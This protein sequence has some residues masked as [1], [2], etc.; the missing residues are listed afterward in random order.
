MERSSEHKKIVGLIF[1]A[2]MIALIFI[3]GSIVKIPTLNGFIQP[4]D[5][6]VL[7]GAV[8]LGKKKGF[9][10]AAIGMALVDV[11]A[12]YVIWAPFTF[13]IK[14]LMALTV[15]SILE[16]VEKKSIKKYIGAF[17]VGAIVNL[18]GYFIGNAIM[19]GIITGASVGFV[20]SILYAASHFVG[21]LSEVVV[22]II[23]AIPLA[24]IAQKARIKFLC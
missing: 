7:A 9:I 20:G 24:P 13:I 21:D 11:A 10:A 1:T 3:A 19:G 5:C 14:G 18:I 17:I 12:G 22:G 15:A 23:I 6:M 2:L 8:L 4:G 16:K